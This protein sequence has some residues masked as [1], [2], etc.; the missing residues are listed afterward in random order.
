MLIWYKMM[1]KFSYKHNIE[2]NRSKIRVQNP[3]IIVKIYS[4]PNYA[5]L[6]IYKLCH[7]CSGYG[8]NI[9]Y[10]RQMF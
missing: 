2:H 3:E 5:N 1:H 4:E 9:E 10:N 8:H 6:I 7:H